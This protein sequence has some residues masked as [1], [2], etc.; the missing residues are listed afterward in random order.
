MLAIAQHRAI[1]IGAA[2]PR[3]VVEA[4]PDRCTAGGAKV[5]V[6]VEDALVLRA[7]HFSQ[8][9]TAGTGDQRTAEEA[10]AALAAN[11]IGGSDVDIVDVGR[12]H[13]EV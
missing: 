7:R 2:V 9:P 10:P 12:R 8:W 13:G 3:Q 11:A 1:A 4:V 6:G 5:D